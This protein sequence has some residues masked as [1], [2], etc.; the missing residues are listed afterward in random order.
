MGGP[1]RPRLVV[2]AEDDDLHAAVPQVL[3]R[4]G[5]DPLG[6]GGLGAEPG[7][8]GAHQVP[9]IDPHLH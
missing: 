2:R 3:Q 1:G 9:E 8:L 7:V 4:E 6:V 5:L